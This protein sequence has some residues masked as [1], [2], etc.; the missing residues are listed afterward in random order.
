MLSKTDFQ[1]I[2]ETQIDNKLLSMR[3]FNFRYSSKPPRKYVRIIYKGWANEYQSSG[4][5][6][7]EY[8]LLLKVIEKFGH[9][10]VLKALR[11]KHHL[12]CNCCGSKLRKVTF[13]DK[14]KTVL[15]PQWKQ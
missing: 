14:L 6:L 8:D 3:S 10:K 9:F 11:P 5:Y 4:N 15:D 7:E 2:G 13:L 12:I 1:V